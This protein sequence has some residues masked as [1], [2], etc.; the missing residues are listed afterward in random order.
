MAF[1]MVHNTK[2]TYIHKSKEDLNDQQMVPTSQELVQFKFSSH[3]FKQTS[4]S[5]FFSRGFAAFVI[6]VVFT[7][8]YICSGPNHFMSL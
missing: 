1:K 2:S 3:R 5:L 8:Y 7:P 6:K 4:S